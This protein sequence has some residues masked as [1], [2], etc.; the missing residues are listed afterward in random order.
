MA[1][2]IKNNSLIVT[3]NRNKEVLLKSITSLVDVKF[4]TKEEYIKKVSGDYNEETIYFVMNK[5]NTTY[6]LARIYLNYLKYI[7][8]NK[9]YNESK[10]DF[11]SSLKKDLISNNL[12]SLDKLFI[13]YLK[14]RKVVVYN[15]ELKKEEKQFFNN[16]ELINEVDIKNNI[17]K[18]YEFS[19]INEEVEFICLAILNDLDKG[20]PI[21]K[22]VISNY[23]EEYY[24]SIK[25]IFKLFNIPINLTSRR[26]L[27]SNI[28]VLNFIRDLRTTYS[29]SD[30]LDKIIDVDIKN[31][32]IKICNK[33]LFKKVDNIIIDCLINEF[34]N[35]SLPTINIEQAINIKELDEITD[36]IVYLIGFNDSSIPVLHKDEEYLSDNLKKLLN[37]ETS[38]EENLNEKIKVINDIKSISNLTISYKLRTDKE[39]FFKSS[40]V[41]EL[42]LI[43]ISN[44]KFD[45][46]YNYSLLYNLYTL[47]VKKDLLN[48]Y[49]LIDEDLNKLLFNYKDNNYKTYNNEYKTID[50]NGLD[51]IKLSYT[52]MNS[53]YECNFKYYLKYILKIDKYEE[54][55]ATKIGNAFHY[56]LSCYKKDDFN[57]EDCY[58]NYLKDLNLTKKEVIIFNKLKNELELII[59]TIKL[60]N[61]YSTLDNEVY[62]EEIKVD[63]KKDVEF[64]GKVDKI[65]FDDDL[66]AIIDY[67]TGKMDSS[68][69]K[70]KYGLGMQLPVYMYLIKNS[71]RFKNHKVVGIYLQKILNNDIPFNI[72]QDYEEKKKEFLK[73]D[74]Y[75]ISEIDCLEKL[76]INYSDSKL[77]KG[78]AVKNDLEFYAKSKVMSNEE[79]EDLV[80]NVKS[81]IK[82]CVSNIEA[83]NFDI[84]PKKI[85][86]FDSCEYCKFR[87]VCFKK[88][89]D[90]ITEQ[91]V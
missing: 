36:E 43:I 1:L 5:Y 41:D 42:K 28:Q 78:L 16:A 88:I 9:I 10:L 77:I 13:D 71:E 6:L 59:E 61:S 48:K 58:F 68:L 11:L 60:Q 52:S 82:E 56:V 19:S 31:S 75:S 45:N 80:L 21:N 66:A 73:L 84:N 87:D 26:K 29:F 91:E 53:F 44:Y 23:S 90:Y 46:K 89:E 2:D 35:T 37:M 25:R 40:L 51:K 47:G 32:I 81:K 85:N 62:E 54:M 12:Y 39:A 3:S 83:C 4:I 65:K 63:I 14:S 38:V 79:L 72:N 74:G 24:L 50:Q 86:K 34:K 22:I 76:D 70:I 30:S 64:V 69:D 20:T 49:N 17:D 8:E 55:L 7:D 33:Y 57:L 18:V 67:K 15:I 27:Y